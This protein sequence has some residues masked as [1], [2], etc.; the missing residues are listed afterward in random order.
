MRTT[1]TPT[2]DERVRSRLRE[3]LRQATLEGAN[4]DELAR[5]IQAVYDDALTYHDA[6]NMVLELRRQARATQ[7]HDAAA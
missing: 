4:P 3:N 1:V 7:Q 6:N 5:I 2:Y